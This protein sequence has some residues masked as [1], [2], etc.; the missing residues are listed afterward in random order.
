MGLYQLKDFL[1][2][3]DVA[4]YLTDKG[5]YNFN[6]THEYDCIKL[7]GLLREWVR[8]EKITPVFY[9]SNEPV[10]ITL[11]RY[12]KDDNIIT[13][14]R[15]NFTTMLNGYFRIDR[16]TYEFIL[17]NDIIVPENQD[18]D[19]GVLI[20]CQHVYSNGDLINEIEY[21]PYKITEKYYPR[22]LSPEYRPQEDL[23]VGV[24]VR[25]QLFSD[26]ICIIEKDELLYPKEQLDNLFLQ[27]QK[28]SLQQQINT[29]DSQ[30]DELNDNSENSYLV[31]IGLLLELLKKSKGFDKDNKPNK[32]LFDSNNQIIQDIL[33]YD[34]YGQ[35]KSTLENRFSKART[36]LDQAK[37][38]K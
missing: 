38:N 2:F 3:D 6:L 27:Q 19:D 37:K 9:Y 10:N 31:T 5:V 26:S 35:G 24:C 4:E 8:L 17:N 28:N 11:Y 22:I 20:L 29:I 21:Y 16:T 36:A 7:E 18:F 15:Y 14:D 25:Y 1:T 13:D 34:I 33:N 23:S 30:L 12:K 32:P